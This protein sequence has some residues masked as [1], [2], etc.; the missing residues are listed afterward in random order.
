MANKDAAFGFKATGG[1]G[2]SYEHKVLLNMRST[3]TGLTLYFKAI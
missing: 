1:M 2:S 3:T